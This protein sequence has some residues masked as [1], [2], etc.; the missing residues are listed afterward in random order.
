M[1]NNAIKFIAHNVLTLNDD[2]YIS[3][4]NAE[5]LREYWVSG[6]IKYNPEI[7]RGEKV[8][9]RRNKKEETVP[10]FSRTN[11][12][13]I[14][15]RMKAGKY[16]PDTIIL[17]IMNDGAEKIAVVDGTLTVESGNVEVLDGQHRLRALE[18][19]GEAAENIV[20]PFPVMILNLSKEKAQ[21]AFYQ[22]TQGSK[23][24][25]T[26]A[27]YLNNDQGK[28]EN[29]I[30]KEILSSS[31]LG[32][33]V[34]VVKNNVSKNDK[35]AVV[36][37]STIVAAI[38]SSLRYMQISIDGKNE[39]KEIAN[40]F[41]RYCDVLVS[42]I[43]EIRNPEKRLEGR[44]DSLICE[45]F[46]FYGYVAVGAY[47]YQNHRND[48]ERFVSNL[49]DMDYRKDSPLWESKIV[50]KGKEKY[51]IVNSSDSRNYL[52]ETFVNEFN[53]ITKP[54]SQNKESA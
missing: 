31:D 21:D 24:S 6:V 3:V 36:T 26:R 35:K 10:V 11:I 45:N 13:K 15:E 51:S 33:Y 49:L 12:N 17:N 16:K 50:R 27:E 39:A 20:E 37:F 52:I 19:V 38:Q 23:I 5:K 40:F 29:L 42:V 2:G 46:T 53:K 4:M 8:V 7:Q 1:D 18:R 32:K 43:E 9:K 25:K 54:N 30:A 22:F 47:L 28:Y 48:W 14:A 34:E 44:D 41:V